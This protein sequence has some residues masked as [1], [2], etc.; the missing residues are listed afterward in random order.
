[1]MWAEATLNLMV[2][3]FG[4]VRKSGSCKSSEESRRGGS[5]ASPAGSLYFGD[6][7]WVSAFLVLY[8][9]ATRWWYRLVFP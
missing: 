7:S 1:M 9:E 4:F 2:F 3:L 8:S 6:T 5:S